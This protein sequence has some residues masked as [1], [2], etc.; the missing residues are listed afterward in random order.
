MPGL[1]LEAR[2]TENVIQ[3]IFAGL[4]LV[5][6]QDIDWNKAPK[7]GIAVTFSEFFELRT[8]KDDEFFKKI[9]SFPGVTIKRQARK[10]YFETEVE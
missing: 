8:K 9:A 2:D 1:I 5:R 4:E 3:F 6:E 10:G 7:N